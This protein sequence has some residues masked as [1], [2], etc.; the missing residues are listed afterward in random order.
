MGEGQGQHTK[1]KARR[2]R[3]RDYGSGSVRLKNGAWHLQ[4]RTPDGK[5]RSTVLC[6]KDDISLTQRHA[7]P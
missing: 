6:R 2:R 1:T 5:V 7:M 3:R 4:Y